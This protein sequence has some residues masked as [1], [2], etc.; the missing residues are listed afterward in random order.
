MVDFFNGFHVDKYTVRPMDPMG[1][2]FSCLKVNMF[3]TKKQGQNENIMSLLLKP[4]I[5]RSGWTTSRMGDTEVLELAK[6]LGWCNSS[7]AK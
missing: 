1:N 5:I 2:T 7:T 3:K 6:F 4:R